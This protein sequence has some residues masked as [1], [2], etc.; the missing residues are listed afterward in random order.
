[1]T[2][3][4]IGIGSMGSALVKGWLRDPDPTME[5]VIWDKADALAKRL[6]VSRQVVSAS[7]LEDLVER[8]DLI[9]VVVK[10]GDAGGVLRA[11]APSIREDKTVVS[12]MAG[13]TMR[14]MRTILGQE[15]GL[16]RIMP[17]LGVGLGVGSVAI[18]AEPSA[19]VTCVEAVV[20]LLE[21]LGLVEVVSESLLDVVTAVS[22]SGPAFFA[23][24]LESLEDGAV[25]VGLSRAVARR[26][27]RQ[28]ALATAQLLSRYGDS[29]A[30]LR[31]QLATEGC[32]GWNKMDQAGLDVLESREVRLA[33][34]RAVEVAAE[35]SRQLEELS[36][37]QQCDTMGQD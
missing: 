2:V 17:N 4:V 22:G 28:T 16:L 30:H 18:A 13:V 1:M 10:P 24:A 12:S 9:F 35:R 6:L 11:I 37:P 34:Q 19:S 29:P 32:A 27:T 26:L 8:V 33:F 31:L 14:W 20:R 21:R 15:C 5:I 23:L 3:G 25:A 36:S 7:S